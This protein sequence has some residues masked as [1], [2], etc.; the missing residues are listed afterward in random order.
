M[1]WSVIHKIKHNTGDGIIWK[2]C[3]MEKAAI[4][5]EDKKLLSRKHQDPYNVCYKTGT[6]SS[7][8]N[9]INSIF[10]IFTIQVRKHKQYVLLYIIH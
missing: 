3:N 4:A 8:N 7:N 10:F 5:A 1:V 2:I 9:F 6:Y